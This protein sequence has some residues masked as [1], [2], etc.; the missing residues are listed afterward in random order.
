M[1]ICVLGAGSWGSA[2]SMVLADN[3]HQVTLW[4]RNKEQCRVLNEERSNERYLKNVVFPKEIHAT[5]NIVEAL[6]EKQVI[7]IAIASQAVR[8]V[9]DS[10]NG[11]ITKDQVVVNV[12]KGIEVG[13]LKRISEVVADFYPENPYVALSDPLM[14]KKWQQNYRPHLFLHQLIWKRQS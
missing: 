3:G 2:L 14:L 4:T 11:C 1:N 5:T 12:S 13:S 9:L 8:K 10:T 6:K 7:V